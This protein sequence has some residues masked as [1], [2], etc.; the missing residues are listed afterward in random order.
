M[1]VNIVEAPSTSS[2]AHILDE[3]TTT[4][5]TST[6]RLSTSS[7]S[8][9]LPP[10]PTTVTSTGEGRNSTGVNLEPGAV[11][12]DDSYEMIQDEPSFSETVL[13]ESGI[14]SVVNSA[15]SGPGTSRHKENVEASK[16]QEQTG[17]S[18][19]QENYEASKQQEQ[20]EISKQQEQTGTSKQLK[21]KKT[22]D[23]DHEED[24]MIYDE[25]E[26]AI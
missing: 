7:N 11:G 8:T 20:T 5:N 23:Q 3:S 21:D 17:T 13:S 14:E 6:K 26:T 24:D 4:A 1:S 18:K 15:R 10:P 16:Q 25:F 12:L 9:P 19:Q 22:E 2:L